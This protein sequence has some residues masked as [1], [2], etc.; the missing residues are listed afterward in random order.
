MGNAIE[1]GASPT[2]PVLCGDSKRRQRLPGELD[3][4]PIPAT[5]TRTRTEQIINSC[6]RGIFFCGQ[7]LYR[8]RS[9]SNN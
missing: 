2:G 8:H 6:M 7:A 4:A 3:Q 9:I 1:E 5:P